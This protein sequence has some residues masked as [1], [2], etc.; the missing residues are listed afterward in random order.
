MGPEACTNKV[1]A[2]SIVEVHILELANTTKTV[3]PHTMH[4]NQTRTTLQN[5]DRC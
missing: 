3:H 4:P 2:V 1:E 5:A